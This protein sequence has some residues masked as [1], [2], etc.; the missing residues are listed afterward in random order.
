M[1]HEERGGFPRWQPAATRLESKSQY[2]LS[3]LLRFNDRDFIDV[4]YR[5]LLRRPADS[6]ADGYLAALR[7]GSVSKVE[8]LGAIRFS[9]E[10]RENAVH[11]DGLLLPYKLHQWRHKRVIGTA[12]GFAMALLRLPR[13]ALRL[14]SIEA[15]AAHESQAIGH[16]VNRLGAEIEQRLVAIDAAYRRDLEAVFAEFGRSFAEARAGRTQLIGPEVRQLPDSSANIHRHRYA[17]SVDPNSFRQAMYGEIARQRDGEKVTL[18]STTAQAPEAETQSGVWSA[19][20]AI[21]EAVSDLGKDFDTRLAATEDELLVQISKASSDLR[22]ALAKR[23]AAL[24]VL[25]NRLDEQKTSQTA[26]REQM[27]RHIERVEQ[28]LLASR[29]ELLHAKLRIDRVAEARGSTTPL[30]GQGSQATFALDS[31]YVD[32]ENQFRGSRESIAQRVEAYLP[33]VQSTLAETSGGTILDVGCGRGEWLQV[34]R[35][36]NIQARG[37]DLN[38]ANILD[39]RAAG[40]EVQQAEAVAHLRTLDEA[41]IAGVTAMH[42][43]EHI[44]F[45]ALIEFFDE[46][47]RVLKPGGVVILETPNPENLVVGACDFYLDPTHRHPLPPPLLEYTAKARGFQHVHIWRLTEHRSLPKAPTLGDPQQ[48]N[49]QAL[50]W[51]LQQ[52]RERL[53]VA[54]DY[55]LI[56]RKE[57]MGIP[58]A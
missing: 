20:V 26:A 42:V 9:E 16:A 39:C 4:A 46:V 10:G 12:M 57:V 43:V 13:L 55:A 36:N 31:F 28:D 21:A 52:A 51:L 2:V 6:G 37:V 53:C 7:S 35:R 18:V 11:I 19:A 38:D 8:I 50:D 40:L 14:Q 15:R 48:P 1:Q 24:R 49:V 45:S 25:A 5:T 56:A 32:F 30:E 29:G 23:S 58:S 44:E 33:I 22:N 34:L 17:P 3:D 27:A 41:S 54:P 47:R